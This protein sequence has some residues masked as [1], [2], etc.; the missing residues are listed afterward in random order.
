MGDGGGRALHL[1]QS[2]T[3]ARYAP[4]RRKSPSCRP[5]NL[6]TMLRA[7]EKRIATAQPW[8]GNGSSLVSS[9]VS[10]CVMTCGGRHVTLGAGEPRLH[11]R[12]PVDAAGP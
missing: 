6:E 12:P 7:L 4:W 9:A 2:I 3:I 8:S 10:T 1:L 5:V 11:T